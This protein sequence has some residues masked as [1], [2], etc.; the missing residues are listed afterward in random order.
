MK[1][2]ESVC[3]SI[4]DFTPYIY[5]ELPSIITRNASREQILKSAQILGNS[6]DNL[7][8]DKSP[9]K[10]CL[11]FKKKLYY[12]N[13]NLKNNEKPTHKLF[14]YLFMSFKHVK[15]IRF[16]QNLCR[17]SIQIPQLSKSKLYLKIHE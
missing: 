12:A 1:K 13:V 10:K 6:L 4:N 17:S 16:L 5:L 7:L 9:L 3:L 8:K 14:P 2:G 15:H 11:Q